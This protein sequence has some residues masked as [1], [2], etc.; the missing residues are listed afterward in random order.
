VVV[1][2]QVPDNENTSVTNMAEYLVVEVIMNH[3]LTTPLS[4]LHRYRSV[5]RRK[6]AVTRPCRHAS[7]GSKGSPKQKS[8][9]VEEIVAKMYHE[10]GV[11]V[12]CDMRL[13]AKNSA[14]HSGTSVPYL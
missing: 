12:W 14:L 5:V 3:G 11:K 13:P 9:I 7:E 8:D 4:W 1:C 6:W 2:S 10:S